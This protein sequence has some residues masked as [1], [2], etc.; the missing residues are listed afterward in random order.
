[1]AKKKYTSR[2]DVVKS[3]LIKKNGVF[4]KQTLLEV[5]YS[6]GWL[7]LKNSRYG[8]DDRLRFGLRLALDYSII[9]RSNLHSAYIFNDKVDSSSSSESRGLLDAQDGFR[10]A[11]RSVPVEFW[12]IVRQICIDE[13]EPIA[14]SEMSERQKT[15]FYYLCRIDLCR[16]LDRVIEAYTKS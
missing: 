6:K 3:G 13:K 14:P 5:W 9:S 15:Y 1:M 4:Y 12:P 11:V 2:Q 8:S 10:R 16:G 7:E